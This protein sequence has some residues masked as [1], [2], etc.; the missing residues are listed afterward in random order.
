MANST[1]G[2][3]EVEG[4]STLTT[5]EIER[6]AQLLSKLKP[7]FLP[8]PI[9]LEVYRLT[10]APVVQLIPFRL[11]P[12]SQIEVLMLQRPDDDMLWPGLWHNPGTVLRAGDSLQSV[13]RRLLEDELGSPELCNKPIFAENLF[14]TS[15]RGTEILQVYWVEIKGEPAQGRFWPIDNLP[16]DRIESE[17]RVIDRALA[18]YKSLQSTPAI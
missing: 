6:V 4:S 15:D 12:R 8:F 7:G 5:S 18:H 16:T 10:P 13:M 11:T 9:F 3:R 17:A 1:R 2:S 14:H